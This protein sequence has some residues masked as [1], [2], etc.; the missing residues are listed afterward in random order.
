MSASRTSLRHT[1]RASPTT[2]AERSI[3]RSKIWHIAN[4]IAIPAQIGVQIRV[5][6]F[7]L[8]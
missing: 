7:A 8:L 4:A 6:T 2:S 3:C 1:P 5:C